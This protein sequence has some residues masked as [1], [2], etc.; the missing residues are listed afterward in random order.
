[1]S[2]PRLRWLYGLQGAALGLLL[3]YL[4]PLMAGR[5]LSATEIGLVLGAS[6]LVTLACYPMWGALADGPLGRPATLVVS[7][8]VALVGGLWLAVAGSDPVVL[9]MAVSLALVGGLPWAPVSDALALQ[10]LGEQASSYGRLRAWA[11]FG[12]A[13]T[14]VCA[15]LAWDRVGGSAVVA[16]F[17]LAAI[18]VA[19]AVL[20]PGGVRRP[21]GVQRPTGRPV[22]PDALQDAAEHGADIVRPAAVRREWRLVLASP[23]L[24]GFLAGM[25]IVSIGEMATWRY[26]SLR[27]LDQG[28][29]AILVG[30]AAA[31][32]A[33]VEV[34][35]FLGSRRWERLLGLRWVYVAGA[36][37]ASA[38]A[39]CIGLASEAWLAALFRTLDGTAYA[40]RHI[41]M[42]LI[43]GAL[44]PLRLQAFGQ[45]IGW[46]ASQGVAPIFADVGGGV[47]YDRL[48]GS[49]VFIAASALA[50]I[51]GIVVFLALSGLERG[52]ARAPALV[53]PEGEAAPIVVER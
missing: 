50:L 45:S 25:L 1:M 15:G 12:W 23:I 32:P 52:R 8:A 2:I 48:G 9:T 44:L 39:L 35:V 53:G 41:G 7:S 17:G 31:L 4:V 38:M 30:L 29:G 24:L 18:T 51:G 5:G 16:A 26:T 47:I 19:L 37:I 49:A 6:G 21:G 42:V 20:L 3:P 46:L 36:L 13:V 10:S 11:S 28:G 34:P 40:L 22:G 27:I 43:I 14:A 33:V